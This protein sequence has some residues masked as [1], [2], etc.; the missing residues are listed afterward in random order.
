M[1]VGKFFNKDITL[2]KDLELEVFESYK[3]KTNDLNNKVL[4]LE[5]QI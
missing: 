1:V 2:F 4:L 3:T 5:G